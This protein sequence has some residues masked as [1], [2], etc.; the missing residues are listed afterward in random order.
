[1]LKNPDFIEKI[2]E[3]IN[4]TRS[5]KELEP[6]TSSQAQNHFPGVTDKDL[7][8]IVCTTQ[9][10][11]LFEA[12]L[13]EIVN[14]HF[15][16]MNPQQDSGGQTSTSS[17]KHSE[18]ETLDVPIKQRL[19]PRSGRKTPASERKNK[20]KIL[21]DVPYTGVVPAIANL[22]PAN[23][24]L[25]TQTS[26]L[27]Q[28][29][30]VSTGTQMIPVLSM[31]AT[32][33]SIMTNAVIESQVSTS[34]SMVYQS[35]VQTEAP[36]ILPDENEI[37]ESSGKDKETTPKLTLYPSFLESKCKSTPRR[38][39]THV[40]ILD[41]NQTPTNRRLSTVKEFATP[42]TGIP[43]VTP[44]SAPANIASCRS[45]MKPEEVVIAETQ[46]DGINVADEN[47]NS[48]SISNTPKVTKN[49]R[50]RK[51]AVTKP[52][53]NLKPMEEELK[54]FTRD[55]WENMR[56]RSK[57]LKI[58]EQ[59]RLLNAQAASKT[60]SRRRQKRET[61][62]QITTKRKSTT[63]SPEEPKGSKPKG[64]SRKGKR[65]TPADFDEDK[66]LSTIKLKIS[67]PRMVAALK[68]MP[69]Q[70]KKSILQ[71]SKEKFEAQEKKRT[72]A[73]KLQVKEG[74][75]TKALEV[76]K[77]EGERTKAPEK[78]AK[79]QVVVE[80]EPEV[81][82]ELNRSD[83]VQEVADTLINFSIL[84]SNGHTKE[85]IAET[86]ASE[87]TVETTDSKAVDEAKEQVDSGIEQAAMDTPFK[88]LTET[89][90]KNLTLTPLP[91]TPRFAIPLVS[92]SQ[93][94]PMPKI[95]ATAS[96]SMMSLVKNCDILTPSFPITPGLK[97]T[98]LKDAADGSP[99]SASGYSSR[100]TDYSSCSSY[101]K[102]DESE[103]INQNI[104]AFIIQ[105]KSERASQ[106]ES[107]SNGG[108][109]LEKKRIF[110]SVKKVECPGAME[111]V[112]S[113]T[114][115]QKK[116][117]TPHYT[118]MN[119]GIDDALLSESFAATAT[120]DSS[121][122]SEFTCSTC[123]TDPSDDENTMDKLD[124]AA[125]TDEK[126]SE[127]DLEEHEA[128]EEAVISPSVINAK[129]GEV[130][131][132][133]RNWITPKKVEI[134]RDQAKIE[135]T[136]K[137][138]ALLTVS[139]P[140]RGLSIQEERDRC[141]L[142]MEAAK[143]RTL[144]ILKG[145]AKAEPKFRK[146]NVKNFKL[147]AEEGSKPVAVSRKDQILQQHLSSRPRPTP[148]MLMPPSSSRRKNAT[149]RKTIVIDELPRQQSPQKKKK[150]N[151]VNTPVKSPAKAHNLSTESVSDNAVMPE[152]CLKSLGLDM[153][154]SLNTSNDESVVANK[155]PTKPVVTE[156]GSNTF[157]QAMI[158]QGFDKL[159]A[160]ELQSKLVDDIEVVDSNLSAVEMPI[161]EL[162]N[163]DV[164]KIELETKLEDEPHDSESGSDESDDEGSDS[165]IQC[166]V[167]PADENEKNVFHFT[168]VENF[169]PSQAS[170]EKPDVK[171]IK[172]TYRLKGEDRMARIMDSGN[173]D[174]FSMEPEPSQ[175]QK[176]S[177]KAAPDD[178]R[179]GKGSPSKNGKRHTKKSNFRW[180][181][182][183]KP[184]KQ[185]TESP[186]K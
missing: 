79:V 24:E 162:Q 115:D 55:D 154:S 14:D 50:R 140:R 40:R 170:K 53:E 35:I 10:D 31:P 75:R 158:E 60:V 144:E 93:E 26:E 3:N 80:K 13:T 63:K 130:R 183:T 181:Q 123:S 17:E 9:N 72:K 152:V 121:S 66:P 169:Q 184:P 23:P 176:S 133:L 96:T 122:S 8:N 98:P 68:N 45:A 7:E 89:P 84:V 1:M 81:S 143:Q 149:P 185:A 51:I 76:Q 120:E 19:R 125:K 128:A 112:K 177:K 44:G 43:A 111:R 69:K 52:E 157:Q 116:L 90:F 150:A 173:F 56:R 117:P 15:P 91:N 5:A 74:E 30:F 99:T 95:F 103:E 145:K 180:D 92:S 47:S 156:E 33:S 101:Y 161:A 107:E 100:R 108:V 67:S 171:E 46:K 148:L 106:S 57:N 146:A 83:T 58:D 165:D 131:F 124:K 164:D 38:K 147:P 48:N 59:Q 153:S 167:N 41:F 54:T 20:I 109:Q 160:K 104:N 172:F 174:L 36:M 168:E 142:E 12:L 88:E 73:P 159:E 42:A 77:K 62:E 27:P 28:I 141:K 70:K 139:D 78:Q 126:D 39:A 105:R 6:T 65:S 136:N 37:M 182:S 64:K 61:K 16:R 175:L 87:V 135:E 138:K 34:P 25:P 113:F 4:R 97:E 166:E 179:D 86:V 11:D 49:R 118:M 94:T 127:W 32:S 134:D 151:K 137:I 21:S 110:G 18:V 155:S 22:P 132:P 29:V 82:I 71:R 163:V 186:N 178:K 102:P 85:P 2:A 129:T 114:E 119:D